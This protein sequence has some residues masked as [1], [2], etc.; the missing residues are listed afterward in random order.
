[1][2]ANRITKIGLVTALVLVAGSGGFAI[3]QLTAES[4]A[5][6]ASA[7]RGSPAADPSS[8]ATADPPSSP[9]M[10]NMGMGNSGDPGAATGYS[11][12]TL[13]DRIAKQ[14]GTR[15]AG[16]APQTVPVSRAKALSEQAPAGAS[17]DRATATITF[18]QLTVSFT[19]VAI[20]PFGPDMTFGVAGMTDPAIV[21]PKGARVTVQFI[22][23]DTDEAHGWL[24]TSNQPPF[25]FGQTVIPAI[26]GAYAGIIGDPTSAGDGASTITFTAGTAGDYQ[27]ICPM[28]GHAQMGM[29]GGFIVR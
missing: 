1:M 23:N 13:A 19:V 25:N 18:T 3:S 4:Y 14:V 2:P 22:N 8:S 16:H 6:Y 7:Y 26:S 9:S 11:S 17:I 15:L 10:G 21:V 28:P 5:N 27:Y 29:H 12:A 24:V 20:P